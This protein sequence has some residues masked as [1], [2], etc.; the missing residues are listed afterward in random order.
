MMKRQ[1]VKRKKDRKIFKATAMKTK[2][3]NIKPSVFRGGI[4]L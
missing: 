4:S 2:K 1:R 3:I